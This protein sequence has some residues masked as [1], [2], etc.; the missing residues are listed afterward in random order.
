MLR[1]LAAA[2]IGRMESLPVTVAAS[3]L[4]TMAEQTIFY[5]YGRTGPA[6]GFLLVVIVIALLVQRNR[7]GRVDPGASTWRAV[8]EVRRIPT[9]LRDVREVKVMRHRDRLRGR[10]VRVRSFRS[11]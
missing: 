10:R 3:V 7:L 1:A 5:S 9:E 4:L 6:E 11:S 2:V 8:Q